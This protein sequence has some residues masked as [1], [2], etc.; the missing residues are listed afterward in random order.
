MNKEDEGLGVYSEAT[1]KQKT[2]SL[3]Y[4]AAGS[5]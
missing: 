5:K 1:E 3:F 2:Y 4:K